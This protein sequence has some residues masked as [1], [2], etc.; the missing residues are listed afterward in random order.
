MRRYRKHRRKSKGKLLI[1]SSICFLFLITAGYAAFSTNLNITA[2]GN[3]VY[4]NAASQL[5]KEVVTSG[6]GL[7][8]DT[9]EDNRYIYRGTNPDNY[10]QFNDELWRIIAIEP[11]DT[12]K[13]ILDSNRLGVMRWDT[14]GNRN[15]DNNT[16]CN[17][18]FTYYNSTQYWGCNAWSHVDGIFSNEN[19]EGTVSQDASI[20]T[21][22][23][24]DFYNSLSKDKQYIVS[25][26]FNVGIL[27][28]LD[29]STDTTSISEIYK[30][31]KSKLW[32]GNIGLINVSDYLKASTNNQCINTGASRNDNAPCSYENGNYLDA[33][34]QET[35]TINAVTP[36]ASVRTVSANFIH[37]TEGLIQGGISSSYALSKYLIRPVVFLDSNIK[38]DGSGTEN[39][40]FTIIN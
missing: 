11:D 1:I 30:T 22:L 17:R 20:N 2:K 36:K 4:Y 23:N 39:D 16:Y 27:S 15:N 29:A 35:W 18:E 21:Y 32:R 34:K 37:S 10:I 9:Y 40:P 3:I 8:I 13:I 14:Y 12:L 6:D 26:D 19:Y 38:L 5:K 28:S 7:Y 31:E 24:N 33:F 25:H